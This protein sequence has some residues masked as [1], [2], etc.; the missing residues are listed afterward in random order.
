MNHQRQKMQDSSISHKQHLWQFVIG[1]GLSLLPLLIGP[2]YHFS[3]PYFLIMVIAPLLCI[4][5]VITIF[6][7]LWFPSVRFLG[8]GL[9]AGGLLTLF[10]FL[11]IW[12]Y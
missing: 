12:A 4:V 6:Y 7:L 9:L 2:W 11:T 8:L 10:G 3:D 5:E 1:C